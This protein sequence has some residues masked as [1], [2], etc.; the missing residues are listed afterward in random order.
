M[1]ITSYTP[2]DSTQ[3]IDFLSGRVAP[4]A[5]SRSERRAEYITS[6]IAK[7]KAQASAS[8]AKENEAYL[9][10][11]VSSLRQMQQKLD[12]LNA[13]GLLNLSN[14][15]LQRFP[16]I[17]K[18]KADSQGA[19]VSAAQLKEQVTKEFETFFFEH[20]GERLGEAVGITEESV[21]VFMREFFSDKKIKTGKNIKFSFKKKDGLL[22]PVFKKFTKAQ[23]RDLTQAFITEESIG[24]TASGW[25][26]TLTVRMNI[27]NNL[28]VGQYPYYNLTPEE[29]QVAIGDQVIWHQFVKAVG[30]CVTPNVSS[31]VEGA[32]REMGVAAFVS[33]GK[34]YGDIVGIFGELQALSFLKSF[35]GQAANTRFLGHTTNAQG[36]K[37]GIDMALEDIGFQ[38]K[39]YNT[40]G[41]RNLNEG[42]NLRGTYKLDTFLDLFSSNLSLQGGKDDLEQFYAVSAFHVAINEEFKPVEKWMNTLKT[43]NLPNLYNTAIAELIPIKQISWVENEVNTIGTNYFYIIGGTRI[44]P[45][46]KILNLYVKFLE[47]LNQQLYNRR[48]ISSHV[49]EYSGPTYKQYSADPEGFN[50]AGYES[51][52]NGLSVNYTIN[53]NID[54]ILQNVLTKIAAEGLEV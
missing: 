7:L 41:Q 5:S 21:A 48:L 8:E 53:L 10:F 13:N 16:A 3:V 35:G 26:D 32:M 25:Q 17:Q 36:Q 39:N 4:I 20:Y 54:Y 19:F 9:K 12:E 15:A 23:K 2:M 29:Q 52:A 49:T 28:V 18:A 43:Q 40:Y 6:A 37:I 44:L 46:S 50:F 34:S 24:E 45:V 30:Q 51:I 47:D 22:I 33:A 27:D 38:V 31:I 1:S 14:K 42:I 11:G